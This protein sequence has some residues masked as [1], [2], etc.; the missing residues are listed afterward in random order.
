MRTIF[1]P[2]TNCSISNLVRTV[3]MEFAIYF[4]IMVQKIQGTKIDAIKLLS[5]QTEYS[6]EIMEIFEQEF[7]ENPA[8]SPT[9]FK[10][11]LAE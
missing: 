10:R 7:M 11:I 5:K 6:E 1:L 8:F 2:T 9:N 3:T 4:W